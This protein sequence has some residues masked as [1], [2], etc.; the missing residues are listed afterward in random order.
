[1]GGALARAFA[2]AGHHVYLGVRNR[3]DK[4]ALELE[5]CNGNITLHPIEELRELAEVL[6]FCVVPPAVREVCE[7]LQ[8][9][10][11]KVIIDTMNSTH[12]HPDSFSNTFDALVHLLPGCHVVKAFNTTG[13]ENILH[14][15]Y[16][17][18]P[19]DTFMAGKDAHAKDVVHRLAK[20]I[21]FGECYD[22]GGPEE[23]PLLED[24]A[25]VWINL[26]LF[27]GYG[28]NIAFKMLKRS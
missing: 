27:Q 20:D 24:F 19:I 18:I 26:A 25:R 22:F 9:L 12:S 3:E 11:G 15:S 21:G 2:K 7:L 4:K 5:C 6:V 8:P 17:G 28:R 14:P 16:G 10:H 1:M 23:V 13:F